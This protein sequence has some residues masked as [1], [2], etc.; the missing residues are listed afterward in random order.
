MSVIWISLLRSIH[1][2][3]TFLGFKASE[4]IL[5]FLVLIRC[6]MEGDSIKVYVRIRPPAKTLEQDVDHSLCLE[7]TSSKSLVLY[8]KPEPKQ[9]SYDHV[10]DMNTTQVRLVP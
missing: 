2:L 5:I 4:D 1:S 7:A 8:S 6:S 9:F 3:M 10:A